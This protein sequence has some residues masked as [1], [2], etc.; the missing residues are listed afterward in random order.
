[1]SC[2][3]NVSAA[4]DPSNLCEECRSSVLLLHRTFWE[5]LDKQDAMGGSF[6]LLEP[7][8]TTTDYPFLRIKEV[9]HHTD[10]SYDSTHSKIV[11]SKV[12][13]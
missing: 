5:D 2:L 3:R 4:Q 13:N 6:L 8:K 11:F 12:S 1:M 9:M 7:M 10:I